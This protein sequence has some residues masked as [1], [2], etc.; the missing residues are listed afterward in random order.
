MR[1]LFLSLF[2]AFANVCHGQFSYVVGEMGAIYSI[3]L[4]SGCIV[5]EV[6]RFPQY[7]F[8]D[9]A[10]TPTGTIYLCTYSD[11][12]Q[13]VPGTP[14][15]L[16]HLG[17]FPVDGITG[18]VVGE[19]NNVYAAGWNLARYDPVTQVFD[20]LGLFTGTV[21]C[22][23]DL[24]VFNHKM[25]MS[26][27]D[28]AIYEINIA[29]PSASISFYDLKVTSLFGMMVVFAKC[30]ADTVERPCLLAFEPVNFGLNSKAYMIDMQTKT[31]F[32]LFCK[33]PLGILGS[34]DF[35]TPL[36]PGERIAVKDISMKIPVCKN[37]NDGVLTVQMQSSLVNSYSFSINGQPD[38]ILN[39][40]TGL[41][42]GNYSIRIK[43]QFGCNLDTTAVIPNAAFD[44]ND[45]LYVPSAFTPNGD[46]LNDL[47]R[48]V[49]HAPAAN[50]EM[51]VYN[52]WGRL[53]YHSA[54]IN[55]GWD[56]TYRSAKQ[57]TGVYVWQVRFKNYQGRTVLRN[58][59]IVLIR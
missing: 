30:S 45:S 26:S 49:L 39:T 3:D 41:S 32:P 48:V 37:S 35:N 34:A 44:C 55:A 4:Q 20:D 59:T 9:I 2:F 5:K 42:S 18:L 15:T 31:S 54:S 29:D 10:V 51:M 28:G 47:F 21:T 24:V 16:V 14:A 50:F 53:L 8:S 12:Y 1:S 25:Y 33:P 19:D 11:L 57:S 7:S 58:G 52:R 22:S 13:V 23:G 36:I 27:L 56:G 43:N 6:A 46:G 38:T 17:S 40:F